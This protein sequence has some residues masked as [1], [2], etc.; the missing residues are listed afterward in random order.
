MS[1]KINILKSRGVSEYCVL[2]VCV[3]VDLSY[4]RSDRKDRLAVIGIG[5]GKI[6]EYDSGKVGSVE[7][8]C[9]NEHYVVGNGELAG[10]CSRAVAED[11]LILGCA[12]EVKNT[13]NCGIDRILGVNGEGMKGGVAGKYLIDRLIVVA[14]VVLT[15]GFEMSGKLDRCYL[16][17]CESVIVDVELIGC[18]TAV[19]EAD[20]CK[21]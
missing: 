10:L 17:G 15:K 1:G 11:K 19:N 18:S 13:V 8:G 20:A 16:G 9:L 3:G 6:S 7:C 5:G 14:L 12:I 21:R 4:E 2:R